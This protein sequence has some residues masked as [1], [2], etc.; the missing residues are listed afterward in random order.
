MPSDI[1][2]YPF[3]MVGTNLFHWN[4]QDFILM[5]DYYSRYWDIEKLRKTDA[6]TVKKIKNIFK[7]GNTRSC[8]K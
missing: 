4:G 5:V 2:H 1:P 8:K 6:V 3:Q 7:D